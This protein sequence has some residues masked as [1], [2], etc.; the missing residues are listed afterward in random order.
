VSRGNLVIASAAWRSRLNPVKVPSGCRERSV[1]ISVVLGWQ[2]DKREIASQARNDKTLVKAPLRG[3]EERGDLALLSSRGTWRSRSSRAGKQTK[4]RLPRFAR[5]DKNSCQSTLWVSRGT[6]RSRLYRAGKRI[7]ERLPRY[8]RNDNILLCG[9]A[10]NVAISPESCQSPLWMSRGTWRSR[11]FGAG[12]Q[13]KEGLLRREFCHRE[14]SVAISVVQ[15]GQE[16]KREI[17][18]LRSQ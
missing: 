1:A 3:R 17:A 5:N 13:S 15:G 9:V 2:T 16:E 14:R 4:E 7:K 6:W 8:A 18:A 11:L 10:R 12:K